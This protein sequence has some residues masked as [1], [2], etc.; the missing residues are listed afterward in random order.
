MNKS[1]T[2]RLD[3]LEKQS[4]PTLKAVVHY[5][6]DRARTL[7]EM[8]KQ[9]VRSIGILMPRVKPEQWGKADDIKGPKR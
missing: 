4:K 5:S 8:K 1:F 9:G 2:D 6:G 3:R 7:A